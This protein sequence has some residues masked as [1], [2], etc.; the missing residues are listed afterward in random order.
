M[1]FKAVLGFA[2]FSFLLAFMDW[3]ELMVFG[4]YGA[5]LETF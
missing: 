1:G 3:A 2:E 4:K 5:F